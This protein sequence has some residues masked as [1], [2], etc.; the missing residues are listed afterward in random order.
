MVETKNVPTG[1][2]FSG[3][4]GTGKTTCARILASS[5]NEEVN[6]LAIVELDAASNSG[7]EEVRRLIDSLRY[8]VGSAYR[9]FILDEAHALSKAAFQAL[10]KT[11]EEPPSG[12]VFILVTTE[13]EKI[14]DTVLSRLMEFEFHRVSPDEL[15]AHLEDV[16]RNE[17]VSISSDLLHFL[18]STSDGSVRRA[19]ISLEQ[20]VL[21]GTPDLKTYQSLV[22]L[23]DYSPAL[24]KELM[25]GDHSRIFGML[26]R[27]LSTTGNPLQVSDSLVSCLKDLLILKSGGKLSAEGASLQLRQEI[28][29]RLDVVRVISCMQLI[30]DLKTRM[31]AN[32]NPRD[33]L[34]ILL[35]LLS[36]L[37]FVGDAVPTAVSSAPGKL[38]VDSV[39]RLSLS[40]IQ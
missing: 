6:D 17:G 27:I 14:P 19:L 9:I 13:P 4:S 10:L 37:L 15:Y 29:A 25:G 11:L 40:E 3:A 23:R 30:W 22:G 12:V 35:A 16:S 8:S 36:K 18:A 24:I 5:L 38:V 28:S 21:A 1:L 33:N 31:R 26:D 34:E 7:V 2:L 39:E 20:A 32:E